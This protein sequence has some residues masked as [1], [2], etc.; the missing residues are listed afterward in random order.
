MSDFVMA[1]EEQPAGVVGFLRASLAAAWLEF[2]AL[3]VFPSNLWL[4]AAQELTTVGVWYFV[5]AFL[6][7]AANGVV[8]DYGGNYVAYV[9]A[10][11]LL[12]QV[13]L[14]ALLS[15]FTTISQAFW[16][17]RL[18]TYRLAVQG[19]WANVIGRL[20]WQVLFS[21]VLQTLAA[22][23][24]VAFGALH[25][26]HHVDWSGVALVWL[27]LVAA[28]AGLGLMGASLFFLLEVKN[29]E[30]PI[31]WTYRYLVQ[32]VSGLYVPLVVL[33]GWLRAVSYALPQTYAFEALRLLALQGAATGALPGAM[34]GLG[35]GA[36]A[37]LVLGIVMLRWAL[38]RAE[39]LSGL[40]VVV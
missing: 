4:A 12:N 3:S 30:D 17:K 24:L 19:I 40:G 34:T 8:A 2:K 36:G 6:S 13:G 26:A 10:G 1:V 28:N 22:I 15:P 27:L 38:I 25:L 5:A 20:G 39:R 16:D 32:I 37:A 21:S 11:V 35:L 29:G 18:E 33:P 7:V 14:T 23:A 9:L 31:T